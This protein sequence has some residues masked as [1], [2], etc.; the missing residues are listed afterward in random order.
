MGSLIWGSDLLLL[1][2]N[3]FSPVVITLP[4]VGC[5]AR[6]VGLGGTDLLTVS[7]WFPLYI[8]SC[9]KSLLLVFMLF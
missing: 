6:G 7:S 5:L 1:R 8:F 2:E 3:H 4:L 9:G